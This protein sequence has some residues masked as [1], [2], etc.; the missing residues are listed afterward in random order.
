MQGFY[1]DNM[2]RAYPFIDTGSNSVIPDD[3]IVDFKCSISSSSGFVEGE[4]KI[5]LYSVYRSENDLIFSFACD[6]LGLSN[7]L[8]TFSVPLNSSELTH[9][10]SYLTP[11][12]DSCVNWTSLSSSSSSG[13]AYE[14]EPLWD[15]F[16]IVGKLTAFI[17]TINT[18]ECLSGYD[19]DAEVEPSLITNMQNVS[20]RSINIANKAP[21]LVSEPDEC[22]QVDEQVYYTYVY[23]TDI[24]GDVTF[25]DGYSCNV[26]MTESDNSITFSTTVDNAV[27][28]QFCG[29]DPLGPIKYPSSLIP[30]I[31]VGIDHT[32]TPEGSQ[33][34]SGGP[35][36]RDTLKSIN[37][38]GGKRLWIIGGKGIRLTTDQ[39]NNAIDIDAT[40][41]G[42]A[43]CANPDV[44]LSSASIGSIGD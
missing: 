34:Y 14:P 43:V 44:Y 3:V 38:V 20:V 7:Y 35:L 1:F 6:A 28:G 23:H 5:W 2:F 19:S 31:R 22:P 36:C 33:L 15:G 16:I 10:F 24:T 32:E 25:T 42:L 18:G 9:S 37:G 26:S 41:S 30:G 29:E 27:K 11:M 13:S 40:L 21:A 12:S 8:L 17:E 4:N 39:G